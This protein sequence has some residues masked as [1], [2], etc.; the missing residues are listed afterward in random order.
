ME[1]LKVQVELLDRV[2]LN[3]HKNQSEVLKKIAIVD[4][5]DYPKK[6]TLEKTRIYDLA[7]EA[8]RFG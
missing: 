4:Y 5:N 1:I 6:D 3:F 7:F 8:E 2:L